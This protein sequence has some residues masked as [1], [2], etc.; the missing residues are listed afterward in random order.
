METLKI[1]NPIISSQTIPT[2][3][4]SSYLIFK[5]TVDSLTNVISIAISS[6]NPFEIYNE[7]K[8]IFLIF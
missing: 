5:E 8:H 3:Y 1:L 7:K 6:K 2:Y 4:S